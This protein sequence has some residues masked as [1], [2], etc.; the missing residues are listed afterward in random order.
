MLLARL[1][2]KLCERE[3]ICKPLIG[4]HLDQRGHEDSASRPMETS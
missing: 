2:D 1:W 4:V 3:L